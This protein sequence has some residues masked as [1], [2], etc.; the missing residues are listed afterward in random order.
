M[1]MKFQLVLQFVTDEMSRFDELVAL[2]ETL[3]MRL[4]STSRVDGHDFGS[5]E[6]NIFIFTD[7]PDESFGLAR[8]LMQSPFQQQVRAAYRERGKNEYVILWPKDLAE[9]RVS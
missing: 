7:R 9:F 5:G 3:R 4:P 6:F 8:K 2:E 1:R